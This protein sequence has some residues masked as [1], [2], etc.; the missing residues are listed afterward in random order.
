MSA[1]VLESLLVLA[2]VGLLIM[3]A[4][5]LMGYV[6]VNHE[7]RAQ[8]AATGP[9]Q[10]GVGGGR[11]AGAGSSTTTSAAPT[12][13][14][15]ATTSASAGADLAAGK[16]VFSSAGC[17]ACHTL[18]DAGASGNVGPNLDELKPDAERV[19][20]QVINGG[21]A[22]PAFKGRLSPQQIEAVSKYVAAVAGK[23]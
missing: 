13:T 14:A 1:P 5:A 20:K 19:S 12:T 3:G 8:A 2:F 9:E 4:G 7:P 11:I 16:Q 6:I 18:K 15:P 22:M 10:P 23:G 21:G 17:G